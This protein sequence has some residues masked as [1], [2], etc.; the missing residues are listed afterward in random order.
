VLGIWMLPPG[1][2]LFAQDVP[3]PQKPMARGL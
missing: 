3:P 1:L 2:V